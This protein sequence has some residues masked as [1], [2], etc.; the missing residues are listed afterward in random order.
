M[1]VSVIISSACWGTTLSMP[2]HLLGWPPNAAQLACQIVRQGV[3]RCLLR[4]V[5]TCRSCRVES[6]PQMR[7]ALHVHYALS[8]YHA[9]CSVQR[10]VCSMQSPQSPQSPQSTQSPAWSEAFTGRPRVRHRYSTGTSSEARGVRSRHPFTQCRARSTG[11]EAH[12][13]P[14]RTAAQALGRTA[15]APRLAAPALSDRCHFRNRQQKLDS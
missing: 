2:L 7:R 14:V 15:A 3:C 4:S 8:I 11:R 6:V 5:A 9:F 12:P 10:A 13:R 1:L